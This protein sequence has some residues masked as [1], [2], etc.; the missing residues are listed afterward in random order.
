MK[1]LVG[2]PTYH[3]KE[4]ALQDYAAGIKALRHDGIEMDVLLVDNS[5]GDEYFKK[6]QAAGLPVVK[7]P[8]FEGARDRIVAS[9]NILRDKVLKEGYDYLFS[10]EQDVVPEPDT[11]LR[12]LAHKKKIVTSV[13]YKH[14]P[15]GPE[16]KLLPMLYSQ[17]P[18]DP[19]GLW[20]VDEKEF[21]TPALKRVLACHLSCTLIHRDVL[22]FI[23]FRYQGDTFDDMAFCKDANDYGFL[24]LV[25]TGIK[26]RHLFS[27]WEGVRK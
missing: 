25:D 27:S 1:V 9:R 7:G 14:Q 6:I 2:C 11:L 8:W 3:G 20:Y 10:L 19:T 12:M 17:H 26:P 16:I 24:V 22:D 15:Y 23:T 13:V 5:A 4:Y 18:V 21:E